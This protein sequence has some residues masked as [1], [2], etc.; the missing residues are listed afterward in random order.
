MRENNIEIEFKTA[1]TKESY[2]QMLDEFGL[3]DNIFLQTNYYFDT[4]NLDLNKDLVVLRIRKNND[5]YKI[6]MKSQSEEQAFENHV[7]LTEERALEMIEKGFNTKEFFEEI[8]LDVSFIASLDNYRVSTPHYENILF[9]D[10]CDYHGITDYEL[11]YEVV[12]YN[13]GKKSFE[14][15]LEKHNIPFVKSKRKSEKALKL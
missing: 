2:H 12:D 14:R 11:E 3:G 1:L 6:T 7:F 4:A 15:L 8:D 9:L 5:R 10:R 13:D